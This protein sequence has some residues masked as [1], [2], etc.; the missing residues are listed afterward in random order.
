MHMLEAVRTAGLE[1]TVRF[2]QASTSELYGKV[3]A[4]PQ[5]EETPFHPRSPYGVAKIFGFWAV[6]NYRSQSLLSTMCMFRRTPY[7]PHVR[8]H[9]A[10]ARRGL[11]VGLVVYQGTCCLGLSLCIVYRACRSFCC[12]L[13]QAL[14][15]Q[16]WL[17]ATAVWLILNVSEELCM[18]REAYNMFCCNGILFNHE[19]PRRGEIFVTRKITMAAANIKLGKQVIILAQALPKCRSDKQRPSGPGMRGRGG[20]GLAAMVF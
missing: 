10:C 11:S 12:I 1:K 16:H 7:S 20:L 6:K 19:S 4:V 15:H 3:H 18:C 13:L 9:A 8:Q 5:D 14:Q 17:P 2:Y